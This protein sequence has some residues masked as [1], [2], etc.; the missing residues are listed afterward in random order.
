[1]DIGQLTHDYLMKAYREWER[2]QERDLRAFA[3]EFEPWLQQ[4]FQRLPYDGWRH[5]WR[6]FCARWQVRGVRVPPDSAAKFEAWLGD[7]QRHFRAE[8]TSN[9]PAEAPA[10]VQLAQP[11][12]GLSDAPYE[13]NT[14]AP[15]PPNDDVA[16]TSSGDRTPSGNASAPAPTVPMDGVEDA[17]TIEYLKKLGH[18][19]MSSQPPEK[20]LDEAKK[21]IERVSISAKLREQFLEWIARL[22]EAEL[23]IQQIR[24][25]PPPEKLSPLQTRLREIEATLASM[26]EI[27]AALGAKIDNA[28]LDED[29]DVDLVADNV[30]QLLQQHN[31]AIIEAYQIWL[32]EGLSYDE[33]AAL[34]AIPR[35]SSI[36]LPIWVNLDY[37]KLEKAQWARVNAV[38]KKWDRWLG[39]AEITF[40]AGDWA[41]TAASVAL[42]AGVIVQAVKTGGKWT[43]VKVVASAAAATAIDAGAQHIARGLGASERA[44][45]GAQAAAALISYIIL[46][47]RMGGRETPTKPARE[48][49]PSERPNPNPENG[50]NSSP[51]QSPEP[52][53]SPERQRQE[54]GNLFNRLRGLKYEHDNIYIENP[55]GG[56]YVILDSYNETSGE[57]VSRKWTQLSEIDETSAIA[58]IRELPRKYPPGARIADVP[59]NKDLRGKTLRG[60]M[61]LEVQVQ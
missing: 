29:I 52:E 42:G 1:M 22:Q 61:I 46:R 49:K 14:P 56:G 15:A 13:P 33:L 21:S 32:Q 47:R 10:M 59:T 3:A 39:A 35:S 40:K 7:W 20:W 18:S 34:W 2:D 36:G 8:G 27:C 58:Y 43:V 57:I 50:S 37:E 23:K 24:R 31:E 12:E 53:L 9:G 17:R 51:D 11:S 16:S 30:T 41:G 45:A 4:V 5:E 38:T 25:M 28:K 60:Q 19:I 48:N 55:N 6:Q 26:K 54:R 44:I